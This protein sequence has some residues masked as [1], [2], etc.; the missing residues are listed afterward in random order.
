MLKREDD[1][2]KNQ[3]LEEFNSKYNIEELFNNI[4]INQDERKDKKI[5]PKY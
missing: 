3:K 4:V 1:T 2:E 5:E